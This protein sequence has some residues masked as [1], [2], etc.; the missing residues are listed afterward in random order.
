MTNDQLINNDKMLPYR[1]CSEGARIASNH[2]K[3]SGEINKR[4]KH[5]HE[6]SE[7]A[8]GSPKSQLSRARDGC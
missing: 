8:K 1:F 6:S 4:L 7:S 2:P 5:S 3:K